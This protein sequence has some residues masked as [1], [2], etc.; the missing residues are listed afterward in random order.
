MFLT[1]KFWREYR[2]DESILHKLWC[3]E[4]EFK[5]IK[6]SARAEIFY[7]PKKWNLD[8]IDRLGNVQ[9]S[10]V[11][12]LTGSYRGPHPRS[13]SMT[14]KRPSKLSHNVTFSPR[15]FTLDHPAIPHIPTA[16]NTWSFGP[17]GHRRPF[18]IGTP[19]FSPDIRRL[20]V[21]CLVHFV[22]VLLLKF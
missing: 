11:D 17:H 22:V 4:N 7:W 2:L 18:I 20:L 9:M 21:F 5:I 1:L 6:V 19:D 13:R 3:D 15:G 8:C 10:E 12:P 16:R 14:I